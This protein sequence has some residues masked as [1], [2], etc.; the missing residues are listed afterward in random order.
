MAYSVRAIVPIFI[1]GQR[2]AGGEVVTVEALDWK[3]Q[4]LHENKKIEILRDQKKQKNDASR[5]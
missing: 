3:L 4:A 1:D 2:V 5:I